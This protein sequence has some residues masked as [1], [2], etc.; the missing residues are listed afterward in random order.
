M[1]GVKGSTKPNLEFNTLEFLQVLRFLTKDIPTFHTEA[2]AK[3]LAEH[4]LAL[5]QELQERPELRHHLS[6]RVLGCQE[7]NASRQYK[8]A[9]RKFGF[10]LNLWNKF[11]KIIFSKVL[12]LIFVSSKAAWG[13]N[14]KI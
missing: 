2:T 11:M 4:N 8:R 9:V 7:R 6:T 13:K 10:S 5:R 12:C 14:L 3:S 1:S